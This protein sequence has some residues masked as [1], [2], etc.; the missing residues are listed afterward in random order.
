MRR[1]ALALALVAALGAPVR[2]QDP[3]PAPPPVAPAAS[4]DAPATSLTL[5]A[6]LREALEQSPSLR[7]ARSRIREATHRLEEVQAGG[8]PQIGLQ[9]GYN[10]L[11]P[12]LD[13]AMPGMAPLAIVRHDNWQAGVQLQQ[14]LFTFGRL[15]WAAEAATLARDA[16]REEYRREAQDLLART[17]QAWLDYAW[18][19]DEARVAAERLE[20][21]RAHRHDSET[22][23]QAGSAAR[24]D[25]LASQASESDAEQKL[26]AARHRAEVARARLQV[27]LGRPVE[28]PL[29]VAAQAMPEPPLEDR[30]AGFARAR[31]KRPELAA[32][33]KAL[34]ATRAR[35][36]L[37]ESQDN[38]SVGLA[39]GYTRRTGTAFQTEDMF[40]A[41]LNLSF[42]LWDGGAAAARAAQAREAAVQLEE[43]LV[44]LERQVSLDVEEAW[45]DLEE[46]RQRIGVARAGLAQAS[47]A[48]RMARLRYQVGAGTNLELLESQSAL[49]QAQLDLSQCEFQM[50]SAWI[51]WLKAT[52][53][54]FPVA[55][56]EPEETTG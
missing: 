24:Y 46:S 50:R 20:A 15:E 40:S 10:Y 14:A 55:L 12:T 47:E 56:P 53:G 44:G 43:G 8:N 22:M 52:S 41:G 5:E 49:S 23:Y 2:A 45:L 28:A 13:F 32:L 4:E 30:A 1:L 17:A 54:E 27:L 37:E 7:Q 6:A 9:A 39:T 34:Q 38:P 3:S 16:A 29:A 35:V 26:L 18:R 19:Q 31:E 11:T 21:R 51:R 25:T 36:H 33:K 48:A 42:P